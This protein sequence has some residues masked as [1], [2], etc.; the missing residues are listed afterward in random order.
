VRG[1]L[2]VAAATNV[3]QRRTIYNMVCC[4]G[5]WWSWLLAVGFAKRATWDV[6]V[7]ARHDFPQFRFNG[8]AVNC[9]GFQG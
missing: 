1:S 3:E 6:V 4:G 2:G 8:G 7:R 9:S 5:R